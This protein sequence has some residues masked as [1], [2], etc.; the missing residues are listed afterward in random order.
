[1]RLLSWL[2]QA[3]YLLLFVLF[4]A[5][6]ILACARIGN[7]TGGPRDYDPPRFVQSTPEP[8]AI[9]F[10]GNKIELFFDEYL[11]L[12]EP[13]TKVIVSPPQK[14]MPVIRALGK[15]ILIEL[16]DSILPN[17][18]YTFDFTNAILDN[19]ERNPLEGFTYAIST[20]EVVDSLII[21]GQLLNAS[22]LEPMPNI[23]VGLHSNTADS[24]FTRQPFDRT[25]ITNDRGYFQIRNIAPGSYRVYALDD[26]NRNYYFDQPTEAIAFSDSIYIPTFEEAVRADT[27]WQDSLTID[28][29]LQVPYTR[30]LPDDLKLFFFNE[31]F[32]QQYF[33]GSERP[34]AYQ[35]SLSFNSVKALPP[36]IRLLND[37]LSHLTD[38]Y[39]MEYAPTGNILNYWITDSLVAKTDSLFVEMIYLADDT[40]RQLA[41]RTDTLQLVYKEK[42]LSRR[43][44]EKLEKETPKIEFLDIS[45]LPG[46]TMDV[47]DTLRFSFAEPLIDF[48]PSTIIF[49]QKVDT[50]WEPRRFSLVQ[51]SL[52][53][54]IYFVDHRWPYGESYQVRIDSAAIHSAYGKWNK[55]FSNSFEIRPEKYYAHL[56]VSIK[57]GEGAGVGQLLNSNDGVVREAKLKD[58]EIAFE[59]LKPGTYYLRYIEDRNNNGKWDTGNFAEGL[60][61]EAVYYYPGSFELREYQEWEQS[62]EIKALPIGSQ[63]L[64]EITKN[65]PIQKRQ[66]QPDTRNTNKRR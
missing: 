46:G 53:P 34:N 6:G 64:L 57:G 15:R 55:P 17:T 49:E 54:R 40:L 30:F 13:N 47:T 16:K 51:D 27:I 62:W 31:V 14:E 36:D 8:N 58:G 9:H 56:Y 11:I 65:R 61:P 42:V 28:T 33:M 43:E 44:R 24:A 48:D 26:A 63:K 50:I 19:N 39:V 23:M 20:G 21:S 32:D 66:L 5:C 29:I 18:T 2:K 22:N 4:F 3:G 60:Q 12:N 38:W 7:P 1:M 35:F 25:S 45:L 37:S 41:G 59:N 52:N 10:S